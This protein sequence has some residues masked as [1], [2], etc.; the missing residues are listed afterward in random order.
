MRRF[1]NVVQQAVLLLACPARGNVKLKS[2]QVYFTLSKT[3][4]TT[5]R[6]R[7]TAGKANKCIFSYFLLH[8]TPTELKPTR[9]AADLNYQHIGEYKYHCKHVENH[10]NE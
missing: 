9:K 2:A 6:V 5:V 8:V 7:K 3:P 10:L 1:D 4:T